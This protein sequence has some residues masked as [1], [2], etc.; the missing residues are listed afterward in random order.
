MDDDAR[1]ILKG[2]LA[3]LAALPLLVIAF[4]MFVSALGVGLYVLALLLW[5]P[6]PG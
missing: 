2:C 6:V 5:P 3:F 4:L 1:V